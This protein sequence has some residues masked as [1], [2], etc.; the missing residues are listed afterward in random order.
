MNKEVQRALITKFRKRIYSKVLS[1]IEDYDLVQPNDKIAVCISG[2]KDSSLLACV[3]EEVKNHGD[4]PFDLEFI[5][6]NPGYNE[7]NK[8]K[9]IE[10]MSFLEINAHIFDT[11][12]FKYV[13]T[14]DENPCYICARMR[15]GY[16]YSE[17]K[18]LGCNKIALGHHLNDVIETTLLGQL[19]SNEIT[20]MRPKL[21][22]KNFDGMELIRPLYKVKEQDII[23]WKNYHNLE[24]IACACPLKE[25]DFDSKR[26][27]VKQIINELKKYNKDI[28]DTMFRS[29]HN[30]NLSTVIAYRKDDTI[31]TFN[32][33]YKEE[34]N[35][36]KN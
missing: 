33:I 29:I 27:E 11:P 23:A 4:I 17:A 5:S 7:A 19:Y 28:E 21:R 16:L 14:Q 8:N 18:R 12:I 6:M 36:R 10:N 34:E 9:I 35:A 32:D 24:F 15:R 22:S 2:G 26:Q 31:K 20:F 3:L 1:A 30:L 13:K 25:K